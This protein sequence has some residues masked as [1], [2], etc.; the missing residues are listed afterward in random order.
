M[1]REEMIDW[2]KSLRME[3]RLPIWVISYSRAGTS[4][5]LNRMQ[6][7]FTRVDDI[8]V[9]VRNSQ[10]IAYQRAYPRLRFIGMQD[11]RVAGPGYARQA[12]A[13]AALAD[14]DTRI[15]MMD[16]DLTNFNPLFRGETKRGPNAGSECSAHWPSVSSDIPVH[17]ERLMLALGTVGEEVLDAHPDVLMGGALK[18]HMSFDPKNHRTKYIINGGVTP[19]QMMVWDVERMDERG[20]RINLDRFGKHGDDIGLVAEV[21]AADGDTFATPSF[22]YEHWPESINITK[23]TLR[24]GDTVA[25]MHALDWNN[26]QA[27]PAKNYI[28]AKRSIIDGSPEWLDINWL[29]AA[30]YRGRPIERVTWDEDLL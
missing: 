15:L 16:D 22:V 2:L 7:A 1:K 28:R 5:V 27:Y 4:P 14:G 8:N 20:V 9:V 21:L 3:D 24:N 17:F 30:K 29:S 13:D 25:E 23:S 19:R 18:Q 12:A 6:S 26:I 10:L 11:D